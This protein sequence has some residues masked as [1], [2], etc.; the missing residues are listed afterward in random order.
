[1]KYFLKKSFIVDVRLVFK[2]TFCF[3]GYLSEPI[4]KK[5]LVS[6]YLVSMSFGNLIDFDWWKMMNDEKLEIDLTRNYRKTEQNWF[7][8]IIMAIYI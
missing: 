4:V 8:T 5:T 7:K 1:M 6:G 3:F 2:Y